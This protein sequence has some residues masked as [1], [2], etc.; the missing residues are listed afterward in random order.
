MLFEN[1]ENNK[2]R[3]VQDVYPSVDATPVYDGVD[4]VFGNDSFHITPEWDAAKRRTARK[5]DN[6]RMPVDNKVSQ[7]R[8][9][10][11]FGNYMVPKDTPERHRKNYA[12]SEEALD[13]VVG[14]YYNSTLKGNFEKK[15]KESKKRGRDEY[16][17]YASVPGADPVDAFRASMRADDPMRV[18]DETMRDV[19]DETLAREVAPLASYGG[20]D[21]DEYV[22]KFVKP[23]LRNRMVGEYIKENTPKSSAE[24]VMRSA[25][26]NSLMGKMGAMGMNIDKS[27]RNNRMLATEGVANYDS[28]R[29]EDFAAGVG[30]LLIDSPVFSGLGSAASSAVGRVTS[31]ATERLAETVLSRYKGKL[32]SKEFADAVAG[33]VIKDRLKSRILQSSATQGLTL[34]GYDIANSVADDILY[35]GT[36]NIGKAAGSFTKGFATGAA[37]GTV[38]TALKARSKGLTGGKRLLSSAGVLSAESAVFTAG[39]E[40]EKLAHGVEVTPVDLVNDFAGSA[41]TLLTMRMSHWVPKGAMQKLN[42]DGRVKEEFR[43]SNSERQELREQNVDP[44]GFMSVLEK[45]LRMPSLGSANAKRLKE[46]Y[47]MLM[48]NDKLSA[49]AK[50]KL[51]YLVENKVTSTPPA[52]FDY[53]VEKNADGMWNVMM[54]DAGGKL[55]EKL[56]FQTP[57]RVK[58][59]LILQRGGIRKNRIAHY[60]RELTSDVD[61]QN[62]LNQAGLYAKESGVDADMVAEAMYKTARNERLNEM[63]YKIMYDIARRSSANESQM[64]RY[65]AE[66]R[67]E[68]EERYNLGRGALSYVVDKRFIE[69]SER[70]NKALDEYEALVRSAVERTK[71]LPAVLPGN[72]TSVE[73]PS[74]K[75]ADRNSEYQEYMRAQ[76]RR[77]EEEAA[78]KP[79]VNRRYDRLVYE[80]PANKAGKVWNMRGND[81]TEDTV[82]EYEKHGKKLAEKF[83]GDV[84]F[85]TDEHQIEVPDRNDYDGVV[86][87]NNRLN[88]LGWVNKGKVYINLPNIKD[89]AELENTIVHEVVGHAGL[90]KVFGNYMYDFLEEVYKTAD[91]SVL[92]GIKKVENSYRNSD[93]YTVTEEYLARLSEKA[94][95]NAQERSLLVKFK[96]FIRGMLVRG[97]LY[98]SKYRRV[99][100]KDLQ[101]ILEAH[102]RSVLNGKER[103]N[104]RREVFNRFASANLKEEGYYDRD[105][106]VRDKTEMASQESFSKFVPEKLIGAKYLVN[107]PYY[108]EDV[109]KEIVKYSKMSDKELREQSDAVNYRFKNGRNDESEQYAKS[110]MSLEERLMKRYNRAQEYISLVDEIRKSA[111]LF[112]NDAHIARAFKSEFGVDMK[113]F[114][115][116]YPTYDDFLLHKLTGKRYPPVVRRVSEDVPREQHGA[117]KE[118]DDLKK[119]FTGPLDVINGAAKE[120]RTKEPVKSEKTPDPSD[121]GKLTP[122]EV[123]KLKRAVEDFAKTMLEEAEHENKVSEDPY[124]YEEYQEKERERLQ[125]IKEEADEYRRKYEDTDDDDIQSDYLKN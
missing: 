20:Y 112:D 30:S 118:L 28:R 67:R 95:P 32:V 54:Y 110:F 31:K 93:M 80:I 10:S 60:E 12:L 21:A 22:E 16:M 72:E 44:E 68:I 109:R 87:Y 3:K 114:K 65:L 23:S 53:H 9:K 121:K 8:F 42:A 123:F 56:S 99:S 82:K 13:G 55:L 81:I 71:G 86:D 7:N 74:R 90:K 24:Y 66:A 100:E 52:V 19:D 37:V 94:Y 34:G 49:S 48:T 122:F 89:M 105:A 40:L 79:V 64:N 119:F 5:L 76:E 63:E 113:S 96:D 85:I 101:S 75:V 39:T 78:P 102:T 73:A 2:K 57:S 26:D 59:H 29:V 41:A 92:S 61:S 106:Y 1:S 35:N 70:E 120:A 27:A 116:M 108:P 6:L 38:G 84:V 36:V 103:A 50:S 25:L 69:C 11:S 83:G 88:A 17:S 104:H 117:I 46:D 47:A 18:V 124:G 58:S 111:P 45:E 43:L 125:H 115:S 98:K 51:M 107:Y 77:H 15:R 4:N 97:N 14:D 33:K 62:F 91:G